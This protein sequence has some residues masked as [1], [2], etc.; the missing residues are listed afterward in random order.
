MRR[1]ISDAVQVKPP[2]DAAAILLDEQVNPDERLR[3]HLPTDAEVRDAMSKLARQIKDTIDARTAGQEG[4][5]IGD[6]EVQ[7]QSLD[8]GEVLVRGTVIIERSDA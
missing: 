6:L 7:L 1:L 5:T 4:W 2:L 8:M 3:A